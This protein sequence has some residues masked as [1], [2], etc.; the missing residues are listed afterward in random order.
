MKYMNYMGN[1]W[2]DYNGIDDNGDG[3]GDT[4]Y[5]INSDKDLYPLMREFENY[6]LASLF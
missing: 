3:V 1:Y 6:G 5:T 2:Y 4:V